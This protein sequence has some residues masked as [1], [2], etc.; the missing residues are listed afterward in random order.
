MDDLFP[1]DR[2]E[3][4]P[5]LLR[6]KPSLDEVEAF[7]VRKG[8]KVQGFGEELD[9][10]PV[11]HHFT[12]G[13]YAREIFMAAGMVL[14]SK[15]HNTEH[16]FVVSKGRCSVY[17]ELTGDSVLI[18]APYFGITYPGTRRL[19]FIHEDTVWTT[20][21]PTPLTDLEQIEAEIIMPHTN[22][23]L[24]AARELK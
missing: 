24:P 7:L 22:R 23:L 17:N 13:L 5:D 3:S 1:T 20:F 21:H 16:P 15:I 14:T 18:E 10:L 19:L 9:E 12:P 6:E 2:E 4:L 8:G 11:K